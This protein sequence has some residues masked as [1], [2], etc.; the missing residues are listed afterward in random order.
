MS[1]NS[2]ATEASARSLLDA[3]TWIACGEAEL[4]PLTY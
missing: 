3:E 1:T 2:V 4:E